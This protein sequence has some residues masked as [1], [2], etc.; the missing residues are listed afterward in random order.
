[1]ETTAKE[2]LQP[3]FEQMWA[4]CPRGEKEAV[5]GGYRFFMEPPE[6]I[7]DGELLT[8]EM[9]LERYRR[10]VRWWQASF[11]ER[12]ARYISRHDELKNIFEFIKAEM[13]NREFLLPKQ[14]RDYYYFDSMDENQLRAE[15]ERFRTDTTP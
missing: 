15:Y 7:V 1:M 14:S 2:G 8:P 11:G 10:Y 6:I 13:Y 4:L 9:L 3:E 5:Y 12:E